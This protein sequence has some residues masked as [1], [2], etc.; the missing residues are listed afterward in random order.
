MLLEE[1]FVEGEDALDFDAEGDLKSGIDHLDGG[2]CGCKNA[3][4][5][6]WY[7]S[8]ASGDDVCR[9]PETLSASLKYECN[10]RRERA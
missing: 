8:W 3:L 1:G 5:R 2:L 4:L 6:C 7:R 9:H 10:L